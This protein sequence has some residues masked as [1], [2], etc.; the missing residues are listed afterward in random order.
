VKRKKE[1]EKAI[2]NKPS[3]KTQEENVASST[4]NW[5]VSGA[6]GASNPESA[7]VAALVSANS[8]H[9]RKLLAIF[10]CRWPGDIV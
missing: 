9:S 4:R 3:N 10:D 2:E 5:D 8:R 6:G 1:E 7:S